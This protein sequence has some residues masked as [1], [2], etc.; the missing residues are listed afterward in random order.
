[1]LKALED[2]NL[3]Y[4]ISPALSGPKLNLTGFQKLQKAR[5]SLPFGVEIRANA[6]SL[7][8]FLLFEKLV[9]QRAIAAYQSG[10][11]SEI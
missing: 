11:D 3:L 6:N 1:M 9:A 4:L 2:E 8:L 5:Q 10:R 7:F